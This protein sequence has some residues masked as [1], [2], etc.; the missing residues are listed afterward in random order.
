MKRY[1]G[2]TVLPHDDN[3]LPT[4]LLTVDLC[5]EATK[6]KYGRLLN[7][8]SDYEILAGA[9]LELPREDKGSWIT[10]PLG[11]RHVVGRFDKG[12]PSLWPQGLFLGHL[13]VARIMTTSELN[14]LIIEGKHP[15]L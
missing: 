8:L 10:F 3:H 9:A 7:L 12:K 14:R 13:Y 6:K 5:D 15:L 1:V 4:A 2:I 11:D